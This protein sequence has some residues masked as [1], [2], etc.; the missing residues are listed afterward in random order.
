MRGRDLRVPVISMRNEPLMPTTAGKARRLLKEG[1]AM[2][3]STSPF[4]I[5]LHYATGETKQPVTLGID[6]GFRYIGF[7]AVTE[8]RELISGEVS[9]RPDIPDL[10]LEKAMYR[11][12]RRNKL[13]YRKPRFMNRGN[14]GGGWFAPSIDHKLQTH[15]RLIWKVKKILPVSRIIIEVASFDTQKMKNPEISDIEYQQGELHGYEIREYLLEKF[16]RTCVYCGKVNIP[17]E[18]EHLTPKSRG[19]PDTVDNLATACH[20]CN[21]EK[22]NLTAEEFG[23]PEVMT[24]AL[25]PLKGAAFMNTV[26]WKLTQLTGSEHTFGFITKR[27]RISLGIGK[28]HAN[29]AFV[30]AGGNTQTRSAVFTVKQRR[31]NNRSLQTNRK[32]F[33]PSIRRKR[34]RLQPGDT[35]LHMGKR[36]RISGSFSYGKYVWKERSG[37]G[38]KREYLKTAEV[39]LVRYGRGM[40]FE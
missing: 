33:R 12:S 37:N 22:N 9:V 7:S 29:D 25:Q 6:S 5:Q 11:R 31:R 35:V 28:S 40:S 13:W 14:K 2:V 18:I 1:K 15:M 23:H 30:I 19:G 27:N 20:D 3:I 39:R 4:T 16:H 34:Y 21:Q 26:R 32:G 24:E 8:K 36:S 17:L 38:Q 10:N